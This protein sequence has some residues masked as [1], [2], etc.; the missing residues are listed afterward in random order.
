MQ[1]LEG[2]PEFL[3]GWRTMQLVTLQNKFT[4]QTGKRHEGLKESGVP[5]HVAVLLQKRFGVRGYQG[6]GSCGNSE[7][8]VLASATCVLDVTL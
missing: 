6:L 4:I 8:Q 1:N 5:N 3:V 2:F 7:M